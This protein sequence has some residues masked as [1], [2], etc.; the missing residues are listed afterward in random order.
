METNSN[1]THAEQLGSEEKANPPA[2]TNEQDTTMTRI[3]SMVRISTLV[4]KLFSKA[5]VS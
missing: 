3:F 4:R 1:S 5:F 2:L